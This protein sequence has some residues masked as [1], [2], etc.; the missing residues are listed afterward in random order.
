[1]L[2][3]AMLCYA[4]LCYAMLRYATLRY[5]TLCYAGLLY[6][7]LPRVKLPTLMVD[8]EQTVLS[9]R[10]QDYHAETVSTNSHSAVLP[11]DIT[12]TAGCDKRRLRN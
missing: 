12:G 3:Y 6:I 2:C 10:G 8:L 1:M 4:M 9:A 7:H 11:T 5:A